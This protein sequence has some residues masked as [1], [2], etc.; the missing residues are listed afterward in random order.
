MIFR[1]NE[2]FEIFIGLKDIPC[3]V[4]N[5]IRRYL[6]N[7]YIIP[8]NYQPKKYSTIIFNTNMDV[9]PAFSPYTVE[10]AL[11]SA[12]YQTVPR[13]T[14]ERI[15]TDKKRPALSNTILLEI[16]ESDSQLS[17]IVSRYGKTERS[18]GF[19]IGVTFIGVVLIFTY[20]LLRQL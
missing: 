18:Y 7:K 1:P 20:F 14:Y 19:I 4:I 11:P 6:Y 3:K 16:L 10:E 5:Q 13:I 12:A 9:T 2:H 8:N 17:Q 15:H